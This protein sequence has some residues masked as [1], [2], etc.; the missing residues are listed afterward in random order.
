MRGIVAKRLRQQAWE[1]TG[2]HG[3]FAAYKALK[4]AWKAR[5]QRKGG[6]NA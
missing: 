4:E 2:G 6:R 1:Q 3:W 5:K